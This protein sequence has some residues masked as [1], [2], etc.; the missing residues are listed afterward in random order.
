MH[1][2]SDKIQ[3]NINLPPGNK[4]LGGIADIYIILLYT[5]KQTNCTKLLLH[6][7]LPESLYDYFAYSIPT[8]AFRTPAGKILHSTHK[9]L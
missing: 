7:F 5:D 2:Y 8:M 4:I 6:T 9:N 1:P 3:Y